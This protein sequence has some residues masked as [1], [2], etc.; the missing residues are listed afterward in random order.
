[1]IGPRERIVPKHGA[2]RKARSWAVSTSGVF[3]V[4]MLML[5]APA[6]AGRTNP[7]AV[8]APYHGTSSVANSVSTATCGTAGGTNAGWTASSGTIHAASKSSIHG[9]SVSIS[10]TSW[11]TSS[12]AEVVAIPFPVKTNSYYNLSLKLKYTLDSS[13]GY[14]AGTCPAATNWSS[15]YDYVSCYAYVETFVQV[16]TSIFDESSSTTVATGY[17]SWTVWNAS[18]SF[19]DNDCYFGSCSSSTGTDVCYSASYQS[20]S[21]DEVSVCLANG[22]NSGTGKLW[23]N[24]TTWWPAYKAGVNSTLYSFSKYE[25]VVTANFE[26][27]ET[28]AAYQDS[29]TGLPGSTASQ[30]YMP[31]AGSASGSINGL[32][33]SGNSLTLASLVATPVV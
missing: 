32:A 16:T 9:C 24:T 5:L 33:S 1:M 23:T 13:I 21:G 4:A 8:S 15:G 25:L 12:H 17:S 20:P 26:S 6:S 31:F 29:Y 7:M 3:A 10:T 22:A 2:S 28:E 14:K 19:V 11:A 18:G 30:W 27:Y